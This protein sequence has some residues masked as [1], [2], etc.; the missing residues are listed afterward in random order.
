MEQLRRSHISVTTGRP[1]NEVFALK[2]AFGGIFQFGSVLHHFLRPKLHKMLSFHAG[3]KFCTIDPLTDRT[4][5]GKGT[6]ML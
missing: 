2:I 1:A 5:Q 6:F 3:I 4:I